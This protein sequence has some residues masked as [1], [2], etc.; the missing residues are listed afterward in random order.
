LA[1]DGGGERHVVTDGLPV[2]L[3]WQNGAW[4]DP[5]ADIYVH[6][7]STPEGEEPVFGLPLWLRTPCC[8]GHLLWA[9]NK[10]HLGYLESYVGARIRE[11]TGLSTVL[12]T[13]MKLAKNRVEILRALARLR[14][15]LDD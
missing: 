11:S 10:E 8:G 6:T 12:P 14:Q 4:Y 13:W 7:F 15:S 3:R 1:V 5:A 2:V 9:N